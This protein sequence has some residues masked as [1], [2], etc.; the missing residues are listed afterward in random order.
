MKDDIDIV[1]LL[2]QPL[3]EEVIEEILN[4][5]AGLEH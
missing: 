4:N 5:L 2:E 1:T 3:E